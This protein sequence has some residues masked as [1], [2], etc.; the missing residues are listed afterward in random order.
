MAKKID[1]MDIKQAVKNGVLRA[2][3]AKGM[4]D[5]KYPV[6]VIYLKD[7]ESEEIVQI[8]VVEDGRD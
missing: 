8:G 5:G 7:M 6:N 2:Y 4:Y 1:I 3:V